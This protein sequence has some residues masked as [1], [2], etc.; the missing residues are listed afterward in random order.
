[1]SIF[2]LKLLVGLGIL[3]LSAET[4]VKSSIDLSRLFK[5]PSLIIG[6]TIVSFGTSAP[7]MGV[8]LT[9][10]FKGQA[11][12]TVGNIL[13]SNIFNI[14]VIVGV[15][16]LISPLVVHR[17]LLKF[18][19]PVMV[20]ISLA[21]SWMAWNQSL[22]RIEGFILAL[23]LVFYL[24]A[25]TVFSKEEYIEE[26]SSRKKDIRSTPRNRTFLK[27]GLVMV[28]S[29]GGLVLG[30]RWFVEGASGMALAYGVSELIVGLTIIALGTSLP[31]LA[32]SITAALKG[33]TDLAIG[34]AIGSNVF[35]LLGVL[36]ISA[37]LSPN[38]I[39]ISQE[40]LSRDLP[41]MLAT[42]V[43]CVPI[44]VSGKKIERWEGGV[45]LLFYAGY[46]LLLYIS[47]L[48]QP[49]MYSSATRIFIQLALPL[50]VLLILY[51]LRRGRQGS[52]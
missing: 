10:I 36:G 26:D 22:E 6:L 33:E 24:L 46:M 51:H 1:M 49:M 14:L 12:I 16:A 5:I 28:L 44:F 7:E 32:T 42:A 31:E 48:N 18:D 52:K 11:E 2:I 25:Q 50:T 23:G 40:A 30:A 9:A 19:L 45:F 8:S 29:L 20:G 47:T 3:S 39:T 21:V 41:L 17:R 43:L 13:G 37:L 27:S 38:N 4:L 15:S 35:N 34:N